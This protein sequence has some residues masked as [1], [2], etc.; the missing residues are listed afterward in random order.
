MTEFE[1]RVKAAR[2]KMPYATLRAK[3]QPELIQ[4]RARPV[5]TFSETCKSSFGGDVR[6]HLSL[7]KYHAA[8]SSS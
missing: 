5:P 3:S 1:K 7:E 2:M 8:Q 6:H 4:L